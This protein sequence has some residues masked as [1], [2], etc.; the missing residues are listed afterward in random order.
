MFFGM[1]KNP[2]NTKKKS[3]PI[4]FVLPNCGGDDVV[5]KAGTLAAG[6][7]DAL[8]ENPVGLVALKLK[9]GELPPNE[10]G[11]DKAEFAFRLSAGFAP[12]IPGD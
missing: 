8:N 10:G 12:N 3:I 4:P 9:A 11:A 7:F 5:P 6:V 1:R 2:F